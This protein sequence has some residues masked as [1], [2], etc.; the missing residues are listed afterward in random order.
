M[1]F[2]AYTGNLSPEKLEDYPL[3]EC[4]WFQTGWTLEIRHKKTIKKSP[5]SST[6]ALKHKWYVCLVF[7]H[8][9]HKKY[10]S[11]TRPHYEPF[12]IE[13][14][15]KDDRKTIQ[16][17]FSATFGL[18]VSVRPS[19][20]NAKLTPERKDFTPGLRIQN[21]GVLWVKLFHAQ[22]QTGK[23]ALL[24]YTKSE[25]EDWVKKVLTIS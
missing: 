14:I 1:D 11:S 8:E 2:W 20:G 5:P 23:I 25:K 6:Q 17:Y 16:D 19:F 15:G 18:E 12:L 22:I 24:D 10:W 9:N 3:P 13:P 4:R 7:L 21:L